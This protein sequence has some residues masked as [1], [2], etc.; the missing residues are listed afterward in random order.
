MPFDLSTLSSH[1][2][3]AIGWKNYDAE[4]AVVNFYHLKARLCGHT[5]HSEKDHQAPLISMRYGCV[6]HKLITTSTH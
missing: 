2:A 4:A 5:D 6:G 3:T 1:I